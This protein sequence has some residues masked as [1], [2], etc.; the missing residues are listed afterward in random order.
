MRT[1]TRELAFGALCFSFALAVGAQAFAQATPPTSC[2]TVDRR[3]QPPKFKGFLTE[4]R[5]MTQSIDMMVS[6]FYPKGEPKSGFGV[7]TGGMVPGA[8]NA[9]KPGITCTP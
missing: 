9:R 3:D 6:Q 8:G 7:R 2:C 5:T 4:P 1:G